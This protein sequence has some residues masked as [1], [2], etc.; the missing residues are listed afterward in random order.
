[1]DERWSTKDK[2][3]FNNLIQVATHEIGHMLGLGH[4]DVHGSIMNA[5]YNDPKVEKDPRY[6]RAM[7]LNWDDIQSIQELYG[8][9][10]SSKSKKA[11]EL[12]SNMQGEYSA[13]MSLSPTR[14]MVNRKHIFN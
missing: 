7:Q 10:K 4:S 13:A 9:P 6:Q 1:M 8:A 12:A 3:G 11:E 5:Y 2:N 14:I